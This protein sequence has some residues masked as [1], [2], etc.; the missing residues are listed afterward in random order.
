ME[1]SGEEEYISFSITPLRYLSAHFLLEIT[2][3]AR[4]HLLQEPTRRGSIAFV[5]AIDELPGLKGAPWVGVVLDEPTGKND[6]SIK[7][8]RYFQ[9]ERNRGVVVRASFVVIGDFGV[10]A[11][12]ADDPDMEEL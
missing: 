7:G 11:I 6:G 10:L 4:C 8:Q 9:C 5:G 1:G 2:L 3:G 12:E